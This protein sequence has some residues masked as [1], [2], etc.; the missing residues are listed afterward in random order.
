MRD[1][2]VMRGSLM[3][4]ALWLG[5]TT[6]AVG[7]GLSATHLVAGRVT[8]PPSDL[9]IGLVQDPGGPSTPE[10]DTSPGSPPSPGPSPE[11]DGAAPAETRTVTV[12]GGSAALR[13]DDGRVDVVWAT[14]NAGFAAD[15]E[16]DPG[17][18]EARVDFR[19]PDHRSRIKGE[20]EAGRPRVEVEE[21]PDD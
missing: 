17:Q 15:I 1:P 2:G 9:A 18:G 8:G 6:L 14:P 4:I 5:A 7:V 11:G 3:T 13:F 21:R 19:S 10:P 12:V 20:W 16:S